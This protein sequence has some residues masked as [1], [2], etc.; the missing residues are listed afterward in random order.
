MPD[1]EIDGEIALTLQVIKDSVAQ[2]NRELS[3]LADHVS[4]QN[5]RLDK[6]EYAQ[7]KEEGRAE[8]R[9]KRSNAEFRVGMALA[10]VSSGA[11]FG[12]LN[13]VLK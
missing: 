13:L 10:G 8:E 6:I 3:R 7:A 9:T 11:I 1:R 5:H 4:Q 12:I 2:G